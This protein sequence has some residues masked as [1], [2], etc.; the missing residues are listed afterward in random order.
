MTYDIDAIK[1][2][3][4]KLNENA[5]KA[6]NKKADRIQLTWWKPTVGMNEIRFLPYDNGEGQP[7]EEVGYYN[8]KELHERRIVAPCQ[9]GLPDP[10]HDLVEKLRQE[11]ADDAKWRLMNKLKIRD[12]YYAVVLVRGQEEKGVQVWEMNHKIVRNIYQILAHP[13]WVDED[14]F[15]PTSGFDFTVEVANTDKEF[16]GFPIKSYSIQARRKSTPLLSKKSDREKLLEQ[17]PDLKAN[18]QQYVMGEDRLEELVFGFLAGT[19]KNSTEDGVEKTNNEDSSTTDDE[20]KEKL[21][22]AFGDL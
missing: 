13:D 17:I 19:D 4:D 10:V 2:K 15:D 18:F 7:F 3:I 14:L 9:W 20:V 8:C 21:E 6:A 5:E 22:E 12:S 11:R 16:N 1:R